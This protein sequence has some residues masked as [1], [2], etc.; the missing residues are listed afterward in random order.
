MNFNEEKEFTVVT[1]GIRGDTPNPVLG[2]YLALIMDS[3]IAGTLESDLYYL[4]NRSLLLDLQIGLK[5]FKTLLSRS[6]V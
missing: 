1:W 2:G 3:I 5:T 6:G 4:K